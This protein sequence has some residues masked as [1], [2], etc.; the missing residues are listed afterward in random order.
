MDVRE[1]ASR[2]AKGCAMPPRVRAILVITICLVIC[3][4]LGLAVGACAVLSPQAGQT[5]SPTTRPMPTD[6]PP[7]DTFFFTTEDGVTLN[8]QIIGSGKTA[9]I[10]SDGQ[11]VPK[12]FWLP[13][14]R[15]LAGQGYLCLLYDY[16]GISPSQGRDDLSRRDNDLRAAVAVARSRGA[17]SVVL[18]GA[19]FG[20]TLALA[21]AA[22]IQPKAAIILSAPQSA[23]AFTVSEA[24]LKA[25]MIPKLF[26]ASQDDTQ[27]VGAVQQM[28][29]Q[30]SEPKQLHIFPGRNH[31]DAILT[32]ADT[33][34]EAMQLVD[35]FLHTY[36]P[37]A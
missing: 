32:A 31:G 28:Y 25:L 5:P 36:A 33:G 11:T 9:I 2:E 35:T 29:N 17:A 22:Q 15:R 18:V 6:T 7:A 34:S 4:A 21:L 1:D 23:D 26:M 3:V 20:G 37:A 13:V 27:Y 12:F 10:F 14:A 8:G 30:S 19:S 16:R 24:G